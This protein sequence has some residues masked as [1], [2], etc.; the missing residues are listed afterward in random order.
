MKEKEAKSLL[1]WNPKFDLV[2]IFED[3]KNISIAV[4]EKI[5][6]FE[7][8]ERRFFRKLK[9][10]DKDLNKILAQTKKIQKEIIPF[11]EEKLSIKFRDPNKIILALFTRTTKNIFLEMKQESIIE[12]EYPHIFTPKKLINLIYLGELAEGLATF[13]DKVLGLVAAH[14]AWEK[15]LFKKGDITNEKKKIESNS[16]LALICKK[17]KLDNGEVSIVPENKGVKLKAKHHKKATFLEAIIW[18]YYLEN[19]LEK[20]L[21]LF[22]KFII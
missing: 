6:T 20:V 9:S 15:E 7:H 11:I 16:N 5:S 8:K 12:K 1:A 19:G 3:I 13:G 21:N 22:N 14:I 2:P 17:L 18:V 10:W 4:K